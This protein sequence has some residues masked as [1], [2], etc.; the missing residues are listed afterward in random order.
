[1]GRKKKE[2]QSI[3]NC[4]HF[5]CEQCLLSYIKY[6]IERFEHAICPE[7]DCEEV[8]DTKESL[9]KKMPLNQRKKL[10][11]I[12]NF[13]KSLKNPSIRMCPRENCEGILDLGTGEEEI[14]CDTCKKWFCSKCLF[15]VHYGECKQNEINFYRNL[16][17]KQCP[18]CK[19][20][21]EKTV[22]CDQMTCRCGKTFNFSS[23]EWKLSQEE[24]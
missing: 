23:S 1:M 16:Y 18:R 8:I 5:F 20:V 4:G 9:L 2:M 13:Y 15:P 22:G 14:K 21:I 10:V 19:M 7:E 6:K 12:Q 3:G 17:F 11:K 24:E